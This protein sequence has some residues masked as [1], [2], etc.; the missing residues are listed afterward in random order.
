MEHLG[1]LAWLLIYVLPL[2]PLTYCLG[3]SGFLNRDQVFV[4]NLICG[5]FSKIIF[6]S[7]LS[8]ESLF[9]QLTVKS[10]E[11]RRKSINYA[12][13]EGYPL[14]GRAPN[15]T[16]SF[17]TK[18]N[19]KYDSLNQVNSVEDEVNFNLVNDKIKKNDL[20]EQK[21]VPKKGPK[22]GSAGPLGL[23]GLVNDNNVKT[24]ANSTGAI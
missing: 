2:F 4:S 16:T 10:D 11:N 5:A 21:K 24:K 13:L 15:L 6:V 20:K 3:L 9:V 7:I 14:R 23:H 18:T 17:N 1:R 22:W 8:L 19:P 12:T